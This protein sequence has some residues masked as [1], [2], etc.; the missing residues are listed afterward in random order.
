MQINLSGDE[1][2]SIDNE[3][4]L[5]SNQRYLRAWRDQADQQALHIYRTAE[6]GGRPRRSAAVL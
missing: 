6:S 5:W 3:Q 2:V 1:R 4:V